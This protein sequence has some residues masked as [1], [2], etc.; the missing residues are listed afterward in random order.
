MAR[1]DPAAPDERRC[2][3]CSRIEGE[4]QRLIAGPEGVFICNE[5]VDLCRD[6]LDGE[7]A[8]PASAA[9]APSRDAL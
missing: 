9:L 7:H 8:R 4:V 3:F 1:K 2:S 5:C 6:I